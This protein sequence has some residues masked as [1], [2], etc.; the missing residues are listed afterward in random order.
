[1]RKLHLKLPFAILL[2]AIL[3]YFAVVAGRTLLSDLYFSRAN[4]VVNKWADMQSAPSIEQWAAVRS[5]MHDALKLDPN[6]P[7][8]HDSLGRVNRWG[9]VI[10]SQ[11]EDKRHELRVNARD[12][13]RSALVHRPTSAFTWANLALEKYAL[14]E[15]DAEFEHAIRM[16]LYFGPWV[17]S[18]QLAI[19]NA[20][21]GAWEQ[22]REE[23]TR[24]AVRSNVI[25]GLN[26]SNLTAR[27]ANHSDRVHR[28]VAHYDMEPVV[29]EWLARERLVVDWCAG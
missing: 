26:W 2:I 5:V 7:R 14:S 25:H 23:E 19:T 15:Y 27:R 18:V 13:F 6:N 12:Y 29:C 21:M 9:A 8:I 1:M 24:T 4:A 3:A 28:V 22:L 16:A 10:P 20:G 17:S 11:A